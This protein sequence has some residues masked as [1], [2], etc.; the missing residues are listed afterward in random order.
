VLDNFNR[1]NGACRRC[2]PGSSRASSSN[3]QLVQT[4]GAASTIWGWTVFGATQE[5]YVTFNSFTS[6]R[7]STI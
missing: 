5:A 4:S 3:N 2:G 7:P 1:S 6:A